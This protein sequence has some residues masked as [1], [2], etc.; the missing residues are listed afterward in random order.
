AGPRNAVPDL[1]ARELSAHGVEVCAQPTAGTPADPSLLLAATP[2]PGCPASGSRATLVVANDMPLIEL[3]EGS[4]RGSSA[5]V[6]ERRAAIL[7]KAASTALG[8]LS[9]DERSSRLLLIVLSPMP[10][11]A[12]DRVGDEVTPLLMV[13]GGP[14][15]S[16]A[17]VGR[18][19]A[20]T[21]AP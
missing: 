16:T 5:T 3:D 7:Q 9:A 15:E 12:M 17:R 11:T 6:A 4:G 20:V 1:L 8:A 2:S 13:E 14:N 10:S 18:L 19:L 21:C